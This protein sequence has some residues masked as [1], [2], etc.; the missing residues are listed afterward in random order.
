[1][2]TSEYVHF[3]ERIIGEREHGWNDAFPHFINWFC[4]AHFPIAWLWV[5]ALLE[6][7]FAK[8]E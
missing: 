8:Y 4:E 7:P 2:F 1:M 6:L 5:F 3:F